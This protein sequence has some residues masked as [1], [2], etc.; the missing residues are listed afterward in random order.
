MWLGKALA[1]CKL[2]SLA[3]IFGTRRAHSNCLFPIR[4]LGSLDTQLRKKV[5][6]HSTLRVADIVVDGAKKFLV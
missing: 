6:L 2:H 5:N 1:L 4:S 3:D